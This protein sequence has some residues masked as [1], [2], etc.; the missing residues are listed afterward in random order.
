MEATIFG[1]PT[2][3][4]WTAL[5]VISTGIVK[6]L[7]IYLKQSLIQSKTATAFQESRLQMGYSFSLGLGFLIGASILKTTIAPTW[8]DIGQLAAVIALRTV[9]NYL[10]LQAITSYAGTPNPVVEN[11]SSEHVFPFL[12]RQSQK[13]FQD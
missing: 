8:N 1:L 10:L 9:L 13:Q 4:F 7:L 12:G 3:L 11:E 5:F 6:A 2:T